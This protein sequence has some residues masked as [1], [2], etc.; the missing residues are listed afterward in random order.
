MPRSVRRACEVAGGV[1]DD[2]VGLD[3]FN[4]KLSIVST[5]HSYAHGAANVPK[6][7][8][9]YGAAQEPLPSVIGYDNITA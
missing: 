6:I 5:S 9:K 8:Q 4:P 7:D 2:I 1:A 3:G